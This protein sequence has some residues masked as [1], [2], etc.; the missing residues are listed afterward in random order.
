MDIAPGQVVEFL[1][2]QRFVC[3][4]CLGRKGN[5]YHLLTHLGREINIP[6][7]RILHVSP[8][9][10]GMELPSREEM[11]KTL[12]SIQKI[13]EKLAEKINLEELWE[14][15]QGEHYAWRPKDLA[16]LAF[17]GETTPDH[18]AALIRAVIEERTH[19]KYREGNII[20]QT[21]EAVEKLVAQRAK[22][23]EKLKRLAAGSYWIQDLWSQEEE[24]KAKAVSKL[25]DEDISYWTKAIQ[26][27]CIR[28]DDSEHAPAVRSLFRQTGKLSPTAPFQT[29]VLA[30]IWHPDQNLEVLRHGLSKDFP[31][32]VLEQ[33]EELAKI[34][35]SPKEG[36][37]DL[38]GLHLVTIDA[39][40]SLDLDDA[41]HFRELENGNYELG[42]H[43]TDIGELIKPGTPLFEEAITRATSIY[44]PDLKIP[45][46]PEILSQQ[47]WSLH[48]G[49]IRRGLSFIIELDKTGRI[50]D[51]KIVRSIIKVKERLSYEET[52][53]LV[54]KEHWLAVL[55]KLCLEHQDRRIENGALPMPIPEL[56]IMVDS[57]GRV[58][59]ELTQPGKSRFLIAESMIIANE[60]AAKF[61]KRNKIPAL[62]RSQPPPREQIM[63]GG[64][65]DLLENLRQRRLISRGILGMEP[66]FHSGL[67][68]EAYTT[69]TSPLRRALDLVMQQQI[70]SYISKGKPLHSREDIEKIAIYIQQ[71]LNS[72][73]AVRQAR[74]RYWIL[75]HIVQQG[76]ETLPAWILEITPQKVLA[77]LADYLL[78]VELPPRRDKNYPTDRPVEL[79]VRKVSPRENILKVTWVDDSA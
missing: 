24:K 25:D 49:E 79:K 55:H 8:S 23:Q 15:V 6:S 61:L 62:Y 40:E 27:F 50:L 10:F 47:A 38:T 37:Q 66:A 2:S 11:L 33:A 71:G 43:I 75:K 7:A 77:V 21:P 69:V 58:E 22:E 41:L 59:I 19:F 46:L 48:K 54:E 39:P 20:V 30:G 63:K 52:E 1:D 72:A 70:N 44:L 53:G 3:A 36:R 14:L 34:E 74:V 42:I 51:S 67:G 13:R 28:G 78:T 9:P 5:R 76:A 73:A 35:I 31:K 56:N 26:D 12:Q 65:T 60:V 29:M 18:E 32:E 4:V 16:Q 57:E 17:T 68:L 45:M 64:E